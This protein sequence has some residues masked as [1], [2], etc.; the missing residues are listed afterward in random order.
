MCSVGWKYDPLKMWTTQHVSRD[1]DVLLPV[2]SCGFDPV[3]G[4]PN[5][6]NEICLLVATGN[7]NVNFSGVVLW[8]T[9]WRKYSSLLQ[10]LHSM[11]SSSAPVDGLFDCLPSIRRPMAWETP[12]RS[13]HIASPHLS[14]TDSTHSADESFARRPTA[15]GWRSCHSSVLS[16]GPGERRSIIEVRLQ[17]YFVSLDKR[18]RTCTIVPSGYCYHLSSNLGASRLSH[19]FAQWR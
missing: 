16:P 15:L 9:D 11:A 10:T 5:Y 19:L 4:W 13:R 6:E 14:D 17:L 2:I 7:C 12:G 1:V 3:R 8:F 18:K